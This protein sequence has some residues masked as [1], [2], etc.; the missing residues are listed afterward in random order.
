MRMSRILKFAE[1]ET[2]HINY[3]LC[4]WTKVTVHWNAPPIESTSK[5]KKKLETENSSP[6]TTA[7]ASTKNKCCLKARYQQMVLSHNQTQLILYKYRVVLDGVIVPF[8]DTGN[9]TGCKIS[10]WSWGILNYMNTLQQCHKDVTS[11]INIWTAQTL[12]LQV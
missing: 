6:T 1:Y 2:K 4:Q 10:E 12:G 7:I 5:K 3:F 9:V 8:V 11:I